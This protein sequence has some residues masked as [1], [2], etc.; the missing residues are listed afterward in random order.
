MKRRTKIQEKWDKMI[1]II[2]PIYDI[3]SHL[4]GFID[5]ISKLV[6]KSDDKLVKEVI[7]I[8]NN[9]KKDI[10][11]MKEMGL[12]IKKIKI[13]KVIQNKKNIGFG[14]ACNQG[15]KA[16]KGDFF[17][18]M[19]PDVNISYNALKGLLNAL[20]RNNYANIIS[21]KLLNED[22][23]LQ[24]SCR[25]FPTLRA[26]LARRIPC[27]FARI[28]KKN[29][30][31]FNMKDYN[32]KTPRKVDWVSGALMLMGDK[33]FFDEHYFMYFEDTDLCRRIGG[34]YYYPAVSAIHKAERQSARSPR[35][36]FSHISSM[37]YYFYKFSKK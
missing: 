14:S 2:T 13:L 36:F 10:Y 15:L 19:N 18:I 6:G 20:K 9:P 30:D 35:L 3:E 29:L 31:S 27:P 4:S 32:H 17:L 21:C 25:R 26:L 7:L 28:F 23:S 37:I 1:S 34:V 33:Y 12:K 11:C 8:N 16:A 24:H 5:C 22:C